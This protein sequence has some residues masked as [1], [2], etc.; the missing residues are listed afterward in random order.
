MATLPAPLAAVLG[1]QLLGAA[2]EE[3]GWRGVVQPLLERRFTVMVSGVI[4]G[5]LFGLGHFYVLPA[6]GALAYGVFVVS[7]VGMSVSLAVVTAGRALIPRIALATCFHWLVNSAML[8]L[9]SDGD[10]S[11][12]WTINLAIAA[13]ATAGGALLLFMSGRRGES[14]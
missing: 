7:A 2:G 3:I 14:H 6:A 13:V 4:T 8:L 11:L 5:L 1:L 9:F 10:V 12:L